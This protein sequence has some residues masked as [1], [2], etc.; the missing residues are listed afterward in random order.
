MKY[1]DYV[2]T[3]INYIQ[4][5]IPKDSK[6]LDVGCGDADTP[7][8]LFE[9]EYMLKSG[10]TNLYGID[11]NPV[12]GDP[13][14]FK[15]DIRNLPFED[16]E[17]DCVYCLD[18]I[19]HVSEFKQ[20][21]IEILRVTKKRAIIIVPTTHY[22]WVRGILNFLRRLIGIHEGLGKTLFEGHYNE[23][24]ERE[25]YDHVSGETWNRFFYHIYYPVPFH[26]F[27]YR[28]RIIY[29]GFYVFD[30]KTVIKE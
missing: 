10:Y 26:K 18:V 21:I 11:I 29:S 5:I 4:R 6:I 28:M 20:A 24:F 8:L 15:G 23:F 27:W 1:I 13:R 25:F 30:R 14:I 16:Q 12:I 2:K 22:K 3:K 9:H 7:G 17:F 19:E